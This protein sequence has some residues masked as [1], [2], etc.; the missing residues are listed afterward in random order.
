M[1]KR[2]DKI[3][4]ETKVDEG[5]LITGGRYTHSARKN[6]VLKNIELLPRT[7][8]AF[9][10]FEHKLVPKHEILTKNEKEQLLKD[11]KIN[12]YQ[13]PQI[14]ALDPAV[15]AIGAKPGDVLRIIRESV[16]A[17]THLAYRYVVE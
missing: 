17:G 6:A 2:M 1:V 8:P 10:L 16:T 3:M 7:F 13:L 5:I 14:T 4:T 12:P 15:K 9:D 11:Y